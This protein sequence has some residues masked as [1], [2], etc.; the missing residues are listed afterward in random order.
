[1]QVSVKTQG[2]WFVKKVATLVVKEI[3][4]FA[5]SKAVSEPYFYE[6]EAV[7]SI[8]KQL[9]QQDSKVEIVITL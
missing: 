9:F 6:G 4:L 7:K 1:M 3:G 2:I 5:Q 8:P